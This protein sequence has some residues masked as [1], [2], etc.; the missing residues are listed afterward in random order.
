MWVT[1]KKKSIDTSKLRAPYTFTTSASSTTKWEINN[2]EKKKIQKWREKITQT[3]YIIKNKL[4]SF[5]Q[6]GL[7]E[8]E[9]NGTENQ[10]ELVDDL[11]DNDLSS[12]KCLEL[13]SIATTD[14]R[15]YSHITHSSH[16]KCSFVFHLQLFGIVDIHSDGRNSIR[17]L[18]KLAK[19][20]SVR[21][22]EPK[23]SFLLVRN[24]NCR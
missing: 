20:V 16:Y 2:N 15:Y 10:T 8:R 19:R 18:I 6:I 11:T 4:L 24:F 13:R 21:I 14:I 22:D 17:Q 1:V 7:C 12:K 3:E 9:R 5:S 23:V